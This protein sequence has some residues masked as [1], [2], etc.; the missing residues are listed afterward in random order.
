M[1]LYL[2]HRYFVIIEINPGKVHA[3]FVPL[4]FNL[5]LILKIT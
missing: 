4:S 1:H 2:Q 3:I 5:C